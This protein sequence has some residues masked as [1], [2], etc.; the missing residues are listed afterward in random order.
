MYHVYAYFELIRRKR[1]RAAAEDL[2]AIPSSL[3]L[4]SGEWSSV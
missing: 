2:E 1:K 3:N 4:E